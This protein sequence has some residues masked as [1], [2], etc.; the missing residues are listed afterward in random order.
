MSDT[1]LIEQYLLGQ[2]S[3]EERLVVEAR[4]LIEPAFR[5]TYAYQQTT[6]A[7]VSA[8]G[9]QCL[10]RDIEAAHRRVFSE[11]RYRSFRATIQSI[12]TSKP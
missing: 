5:E 2:L 6:L 12:F 1:I 10:E 9:R 11:R 4:L 7:L 3:G 8:Y